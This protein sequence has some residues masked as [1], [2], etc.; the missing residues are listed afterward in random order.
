[1][2]EQDVESEEKMPAIKRESIRSR[3][4]CSL[5]QDVVGVVTIFSPGL[6]GLLLLLHVRHTVA[7]CR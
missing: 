2:D 1:M 4:R 5:G 7:S 6:T 3:K